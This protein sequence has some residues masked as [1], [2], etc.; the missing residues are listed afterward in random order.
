MTYSKYLVNGNVTI[1]FN[2]MQIKRADHDTSNDFIT[3][4][5]DSNK[6]LIAT[7]ITDGKPN[8]KLDFK[9]D[10]NILDTRNCYFK[11]V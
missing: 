1:G 11:L 10:W 9:S 7:I 5:L 8:I 6:K 3:F 2:Q 4:L